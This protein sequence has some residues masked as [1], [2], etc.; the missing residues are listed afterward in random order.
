MA[1]QWAEQAQEEHLKEIEVSLMPEW[2]R[3]SDGQ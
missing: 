1:D 2:D 3:A